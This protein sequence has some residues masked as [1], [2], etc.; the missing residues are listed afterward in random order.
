MVESHNTNLENGD[1][2]EIYFHLCEALDV[3]FN[4]RDVNL[5]YEQFL[6]GSTI[7]RGHFHQIWMLI[8][9]SLY[10]RNLAILN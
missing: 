2:K 6:K 7:W 5:T 10:Y 3:G 4:S 1:A 8:I 9:M